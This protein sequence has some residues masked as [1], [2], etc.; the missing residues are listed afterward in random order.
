[1]ATT[2]TKKDKSPYGG[3]DDADVSKTKRNRQYLRHHG[4]YLLRVLE[5]RE[6]QNPDEGD[7]FVAA[8][9]QVLHIFKGGSKRIDRETK[10]IVEDDPI[11]VGGVYE[12]YW[13]TGGKWR[14]L[15]WRDAK[16]F[17]MAAAGVDPTSAEAAEVNG[18]FFA[19][20]VEENTLRGEL[21][22]VEQVLGVKGKKSENAGDPKLDT[23]CSR[24]EDAETAKKKFAHVPMPELQGDDAASESGDD[25]DDEN[26]SS[27]DD[28]NDIPF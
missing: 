22:V 3:F 4:K 24:V 10:Q 23:Y 27:D 12:F 16:F 11:E 25:D 14:K 13:V 21:L 6:D 28:G 15:G 1:M 17:V 2:K 18:A 9:V 26:G 7:A 8:T 19:V 20:A 5:L